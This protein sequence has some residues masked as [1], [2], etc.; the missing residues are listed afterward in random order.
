MTLF[1][2]PVLLFVGA[3]VY[4]MRQA[5]PRFTLPVAPPPRHLGL[6]ASGVDYYEPSDFFTKCPDYTWLQASCYRAGLG[7]TA[8]GG[9]PAQTVLAS[10]LSFV[11]AQ[12]LAGFMRVWVSL[13]QLMRWDTTRGFTGYVAAA[14]DNLDQAL[15]EFAQR[16]LGVDLVLFVY[17]HR[18]N[19]VNQFQPQ[20][21]DGLHPKLREGYLRAVRLFIRHLAANPTDAQTVKVID[22]QNEPYFQLEQYFDSAAALGT[23]GSCMGPKETVRT[24]CLDEKIVHPWLKDLYRTARAASTRFPYTESDTGRL[25]NTNATEQA[26][27]MR[28][29]PVDVYDI[30]MYDSTP[31]RHEARWNTALHLRK[32]WFSGEVGCN[33]GDASCTYSGTLAAPVD[34]WWLANLS[35][36]RAQSV[37]IENHVTLWQYAY[38]MNSQALTATGQLLQCHADPRLVSCLNSRS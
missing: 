15:R 17:S 38:G 34:R 24:S 37:L 11:R 23:Y 16:R 36:Y 3:E 35:R 19:V 32:P 18:S 8:Q 31:W 6:P 7:S 20:A 25:L 26:F 14:L 28:M 30:H 27:W 1:T 2:L 29:Y 5:V 13:D 33:S 12:R 21:L 22:L 10:D 9:R 4:G